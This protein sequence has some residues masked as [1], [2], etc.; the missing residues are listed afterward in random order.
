MPKNVRSE[1]G[2]DD[3]PRDVYISHY[4][5]VYTDP[6]LPTSWMVLEALSFGKVS[7]LFTYLKTEDKRVIASAFNL[8][9][10]FFKS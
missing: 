9:H 3:E 7:K 10:P 4:R 1:I 6:E 2:Y 5:A 8:K